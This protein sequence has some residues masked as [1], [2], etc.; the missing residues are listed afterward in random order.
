MIDSE[1]LLSNVN[2][3]DI[4]GKHVQLTKKGSEHEGLCPFH[5]DTKPSMKVSERK[6]IY[7]C[8]SCG[9]GG[10]AIDFLQRKGAT[11]HEA[12]Q[13]LGNAPVY[14]PPPSSKATWV[15]AVPDS[16]PIE[17]KHYKFGNPTRAWAYH[18]RE[19]VIIGYACR[20]EFQDGTKDVLPF[21]FKTDG[22]KSRWRWQAFDEKR[23]LYNLHLITQ[24]AEK[25]IVVVEGEKTA[26]SLQERLPS[27]VVTT[28]PGGG[29]ALG[30]AHFSPLNGR[31]V[32]FWPDNDVPGFEAM[33]KIASFLENPKTVKFVKNPP[34]AGK[35]WDVA[36]AHWSAD[37]VRAYMLANMTDEIIREPEPEQPEYPPFEVPDT[38]DPAPNPSNEYNPFR[39]LGYNKTETGSNEFYVYSYKSKQVLRFTPSGFTKNAMVQLADIG[40]WEHKFHAKSGF[41][42]EMASQYLMNICYDQGV[43]D[44]DNIRGIGAWYDEGRV[45]IHA[46]THLVANGAKYDLRDFESRN[47]YEANKPFGFEL[48]QS[49][50]SR[51]AH[52]FLD[53]IQMM[54][55]ERPVNAYLFA[56]WCIIAPVC[57]ALPWRPHVWITGSSGTGK[58]TAF[59]ILKRMIGKIAVHAQGV[60]TEAGVRQTLGHDARPVI[61]DEAD[62]DGRNDTE[63]LQSILAL[64]RASSS[65]DGGLIIKGGQTG[66]SKS[67]QVR[68][69]FAFAS[70][71]PKV[72]NQADKSRVTVLSLVKSLDTKKAADSWRK[73]QKVMAEMLTSDYPEA[74]VART[75]SILPAI[76]DNARIFANAAA[77]V[78]GEQRSGDQLGALL[79]GAYSLHS[80]GVI[81]FEDA[82]KW[83][84]SKNW[85]EIRNTESDELT[86]LSRLMETMTTVESSGGAKLERT[87]GELIM[88]GSAEFTPE[89]EVIL[90][91]DARARLRRLGFK[92]VEGGFLVA[93][94]ST[95]IDGMLKETNWTKN[96]G[97][98]LS[99]I[100]GSRQENSTRFSHTSSR[101]VFIP[102]SYLE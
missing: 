78:L 3:V 22:S 18:N 68:S 26:E 70:I 14:T 76:I 64:V 43:Y 29:K 31:K 97:K 81:A 8:F 6:Q 99:R 47:I 37:E 95:Y 86:L 87:I 100:E 42:L 40:W 89:G 58:T 101:A 52:R 24:Q 30:K 51:D 92:N 102:L 12:V 55:W 39:A 79:A 44:Q 54:N 53:L 28:W 61:F 2:I 32:I 5:I 69:C 75:L 27:A 25:T 49:L 63:R 60:T 36:D 9:A 1:P 56:G 33:A 80:N 72:Q 94:S 23:P 21:T 90:P 65:S 74:M 10:D 48:K 4:I 15:D 34:E 19:G 98:I 11:F 91:Q 7:K 67:F 13:D 50:T 84:E 20:F 82:V 73:M 16:W 66:S 88:L 35:G 93:N 45:I 57:G 77:A 17:I 38:P 59:G 62:S 46:G 41:D 83:V 71:S 85:D 96:H